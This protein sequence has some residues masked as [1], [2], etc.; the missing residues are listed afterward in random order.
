[1]AEKKPLPKGRK[2]KNLTYDAFNRKFPRLGMARLA[3]RDDPEAKE[4]LADL[5]EYVWRYRRKR[6]YR[7]PGRYS[8]DRR[9]GTKFHTVMVPLEAYQKLKEI[10]KF[11]KKSM[12]SVLREQID[13]VFEETYKQAELLAR[14][15]AN[16]KAD[17]TSDSDKPRR[18]Y[19]V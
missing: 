1:M 6:K 16:R 13:V 14:I 4:K 10:A 11:Y 7:Y 12:A 17:E 9:P 8:P 5:K 19:N 18:R 3:A 2:W 15:E